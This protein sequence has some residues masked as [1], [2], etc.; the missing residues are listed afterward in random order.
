MK[1]LLIGTICLLFLGFMGCVEK[2]EGGKPE[3]VEN[4]RFDQAMLNLKEIYPEV[5]IRINQTNNTENRVEGCRPSQDASCT[6]VYISNLP[7]DVNGCTVHV[8]F[9]AKLCFDLNNIT[10]V[11]IWGLEYIW[12]NDPDC[13]AIRNQW[14]YLYTQGRTGELEAALNDFYRL[15]TINTE[16]AFVV[17]VFLSPIDCDSQGAHNVSSF[18]E[19]DCQTICAEQI[20]LDGDIIF[21][22]SRIK[23]GNACCRR[24][25]PW[26]VKNGVWI[27]PGPPDLVPV[28]NP[29]C[30]PV[31]YLCNGNPIP[32]A[33]C[34]HPCDRL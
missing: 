16:K 27:N 29:V 8:S 11:G 2:N 15:L 12:T 7:V 33:T 6:E 4:F 20:D 21:N 31:N 18:Y 13:N 19:M 23:C 5:G 17:P 30:D 26:C 1:N 10:L 25:T 32:N 34:M 14:S 3:S 24:I 22:I 9:W 28:G